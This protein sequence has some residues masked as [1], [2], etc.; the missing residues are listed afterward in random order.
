MASDE[1]ADQ[2]VA[3]LTEERR[4]ARYAKYLEADPNRTYRLATRTYGIPWDVRLWTTMPP[5]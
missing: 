3:S 5:S 1:V 4:Q 2:H